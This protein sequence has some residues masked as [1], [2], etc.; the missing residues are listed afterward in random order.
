MNEKGLTTQITCFLIVTMLLVFSFRVGDRNVCVL[1][2]NWLEARNGGGGNNDACV[3]TAMEK[4]EI[5]EIPKSSLI[6]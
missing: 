1:G 2:T 3:Q 4:G 5:I 6:H